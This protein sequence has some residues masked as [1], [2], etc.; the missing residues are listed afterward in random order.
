MGCAGIGRKSGVEAVMMNDSLLSRE[1]TKAVDSRGLLLFFLML[2]LGG[3]FSSSVNSAPNSKQ[4]LIFVAPEGVD[5]GKAGSGSKSRPYRS[6]QFALSQ[7]KKGQTIILRE[8]IY[9]EAINKRGLR[10]VTIMASPGERVV[11]DGTLDL[12]SIAATD[13]EKAGK[14]IYRIKVDRSVWQLFVDGKQQVPARWPNASFADESIYSRDVWAR[15][16]K[17]KSTNGEAYNEP[18]VHDL[19]ASGLDA[20]DALV[21]AN[22]GSFQTW[23]RKV[24]SH[25]SGENQ[26]LFDKVPSFK[27]KHLY[28]YLEGKLDFLDQPD[29]WFFDPQQQ[30]IYLY[31][32]TKPAG[33]IRGKVQSYAIQGKNWRNVSVVGVNFFA[34][35]F[36]CEGCNN[37]VVEDANFDY[38]SVSKR[39]LGVQPYQAEMT[40]FS[41]SGEQ[42]GL[43]IR[44][45]NINNTDSQALVVKANRAVI[46]NCD[47]TNIDYA[48]S[49]S[50]HHGESV[51]LDGVGNIFRGN[52]IYNAGG[53]SSLSAT[54][55]FVAE[56][57]D[58]SRTGYAQ[59]DGAMIH[60][61]IP[62]QSGVKVRFN[63]CHDS[64]KYGIRFDAPIPPT[65][66]GNNGLIH[67]NVVWNSGGIMVKGERHKIFHN[68]AFGNKDVDLSILDDSA[69]NGGANRGSVTRNNVAGS[70]SGDRAKL[71]LIPGVASA[72]INGVEIE[73]VE[74]DAAVLDQLTRPD[75]L[76]FRPAKN[77]LL[78]GL[79]EPVPGFQYADASSVD[80]G[81]Y[82][83]D[84]GYYWIPGRQ[85]AIASRPIPAN[86]AEHI[87]R[88]TNLI[89]LAAYRA[90]IHLLYFG[91]DAEVVRTARKTST[92][93]QGTF[94]NQNIFDPGQLEAGRYYWRVDSIVYGRLSKGEI[95]RFDVQ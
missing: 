41:A 50:V 58:I 78:L 93:Y 75:Q 83:R 43:V 85:R 71:W 73:G 81:P 66:W 22:F 5:V 60:V 20:S 28:Y 54:S 52:T 6:L 19:A 37:L 10:D 70:I 21:I 80:I 94:N 82:Q 56:F 79:G 9:H 49:D 57:N 17:N 23:T 8:G 11:F 63:W 77:S 32:E 91:G 38:A 72:N 67:H 16:D 3:V 12:A 47:F 51:H 4:Q 74:N 7:V 76:D 24:T 26:F 69:V 55:W 18:S 25:Q 88:D 35:T 61:R 29:E 31:S 46:E 87:N 92:A 36:K 84:S 30:F 44:N 48:S 68:L 65:H 64:P 53:S 95:W 15:A 62:S 45:C 89:W 27:G 90:D 13:W 1:S 14:N 40:Y 33:N 39:M 34:S 86:G 2:M 42:S 59:S